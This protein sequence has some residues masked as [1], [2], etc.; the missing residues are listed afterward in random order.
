MSMAIDRIMTAEAER[1]WCG[2]P[3]VA[4]ITAHLCGI[5]DDTGGHDERAC[6]DASC[7]CQPIPCGCDAYTQPCY[8][9]VESGRRTDP[10]EPRYADWLDAPPGYEG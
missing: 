7:V 6:A 10:H 4:G 3:V 9:C 5:M 1:D 2:C 8:E